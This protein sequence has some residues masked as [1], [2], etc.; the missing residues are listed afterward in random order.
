[1]QPR[2]G[3]HERC[4]GSAAEVGRGDEFRLRRVGGWGGERNSGCKGARGKGFARTLLVDGIGQQR[5]QKVHTH[6]LVQSP[7]GAAEL[8]LHLC[9]RALTDGRHRR[10]LAARLAADGHRRRGEQQPLGESSPLERL[11]GE[12]VERADDVE[13]G[14][15]ARRAR[16]RVGEQ[17]GLKRGWRE[18]ASD[19]RRV[20]RRRGGNGGAGAAV[21]ERSTALRSPCIAP[22]RWPWKVME[23]HGR[24]WE[25][26]GGHR[27]SWKL[28]VYS[29]SAMAIARSA[30]MCSWSLASLSSPSE[31]SPVGGG[32]L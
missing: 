26:I 28:T 31:W 6:R 25:L 13:G 10:V 2:C 7:S 30:P 29:S 9:L 12:Q 23:G 15:I 14:G 17:A 20:I 22:R 27:R 18:A 19:P 11:L 3:Q 32:S 21:G 16:P 1:M 24:A 4:E 8:R 5:R